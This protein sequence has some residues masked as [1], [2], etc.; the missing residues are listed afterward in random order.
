MVKTHEKSRFEIWDI[1]YINYPGQRYDEDKNLIILQIERS[2]NN[3]DYIVEII[4][5]DDY[6]FGLFSQ[7]RKG[8]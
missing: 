3:D 6:K 4:K 2:N 7:H 8:D 5:P 1:D